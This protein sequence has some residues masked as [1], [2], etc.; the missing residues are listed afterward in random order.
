MPLD[1]MIAARLFLVS[2]DLF[3]MG[4]WNKAH[5]SRK[6]EY[7]EDLHHDLMALRAA[8]EAKKAMDGDDKLW[9]ALGEWAG[10]EA[11]AQE[12]VLGG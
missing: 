6:W 11:D 9:E 12:R 4:L 5:E 10:K 2:A 8:V 7:S 3:S 1:E